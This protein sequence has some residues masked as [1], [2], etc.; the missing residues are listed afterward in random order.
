M[1]KILFSVAPLI[2]FLVLVGFLWQ[3]LGDDPHRIPSILI[4][5]PVPH[6][7]LPPL[8][9]GESRFTD[10]DL[11]GHISIVNVWASWC[12]AC[13]KDHYMLMNLAREYKLAVYGIDYKD[14]RNPAL[15]F[16]SNMGDPYRKIGFDKYG[17]TAINWGVYGAPE[18]FIVDP[19]GIIRFKQIGAIN[20]STWKRELLPIIEK[21]QSE[22]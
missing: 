11:Q 5:K 18:L 6:F 4:D 12:L 20:P 9:Q 17:N 7:N 3:G 10:A 21:I 15:I 13:R 1:K 22:A 19:H 14:E 2:V 8:K 16:L